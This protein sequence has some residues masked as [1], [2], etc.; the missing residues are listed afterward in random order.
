[1]SSYGYVYSQT[2]VGAIHEEIARINGNASH[3]VDE[4][5]CQ[6]RDIRI[7]ILLRGS[8][9]YNYHIS[10]EIK[11]TLLLLLLLLLLVVLVARLVLFGT[12]N[13][14]TRPITVSST[15]HVN[16]INLRNAVSELK[17]VKIIH[18]LIGY[19]TVQD[20]NY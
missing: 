10:K 2:S 14:M 12:S 17:N 20:S 13:N 3:H 19:Y 18:A 5:Q 11:N 6:V 16:A 7:R 8:V 15:L 4:F 1:V 9:F